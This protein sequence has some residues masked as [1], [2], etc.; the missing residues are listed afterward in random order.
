L[1]ARQREYGFRPENLVGR[2]RSA[3]DQQQSWEKSAGEIDAMV[4]RVG[5][6]RLP[7]VRVALFVRASNRGIVCALKLKSIGGSKGCSMSRLRSIGRIQTN[8][9]R[10][11]GKV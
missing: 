3:S 10:S 5:H 9:G 7:E 4:T 6:C 11:F 8:L 1:A 2:R